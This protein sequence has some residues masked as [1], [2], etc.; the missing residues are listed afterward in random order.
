MSTDKTEQAFRGATGALLWAAERVVQAADNERLDGPML[1]TLKTACAELRAAIRDDV[2]AAPPAQ[3]QEPNNDEVI[4]PKCTHQ[5]RAIP[6]SVQRLMLDAGFEPPF[7]APPARSEQGAN[8]ALALERSRALGAKIKDGIAE[9]RA[10][11]AS[12]PR[13]VEPQSEVPRDVRRAAVATLA[14]L[15]CEFPREELNLRDLELIAVYIDS[16]TKE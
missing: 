6:A 10:L 16:V 3:P 1:A 13:A 12:P 5:F 8:E 15:T 4:C 11:A 14:A 9:L 2:N 7:T